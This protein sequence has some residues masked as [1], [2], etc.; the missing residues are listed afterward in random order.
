MRKSEKRQLFKNVGSSWFSLATN[1]V[2]GVL[3][4][5]FILHHLG[6]AAFGIWVLIFSITGYY[7]LFDLGIRSSIVRFVSKFSAVEDTDNLARVINTSFGIYSIIGILAMLVTLAGTIY[8]DSIF[9]IPPQ[10]HSTAQWLLLI[11]GTSVAI[12]FPLGV[13]GGIL[14]GLQRFDVL[15][16]TGL[17]ATLLRA[18]LIVIALK[19]GHGLLMIAIITTGLPLIGTLVRAWMAM[20]LVHVPIGLRYI[21]KAT[22]RSMANYSGLSFMIIISARLRFQTD[23]IVLGTMLSTAAITQF[24]IGA[25]IVD[26]ANDVVH[27]LAQIFVPMS[28]QSEAKGD[29]P[30][31]RKMLIGGN[32][33]CAFVILPICIVLILLGKALIEVWVG[34]KYVSVSYPVLVVLVIPFTLLLA[35]AVSARILIGMGR[36][37]TFG[38][39]TLIEGVANVV[40]SVLL[41]RP[42]G[43]FG[44]AVGTAIPLTCTMLVF[45]PR[46]I[47]RVLGVSVWTYLK[48][49]YTLPLLV[50]TPMLLTLLLMRRWFVPH[51]FLPLML[52]LAV[53]GAV[54]GVGLFWLYAKDHAFRIDE[55]VSAGNMTLTEDSVLPEHV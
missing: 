40:L 15:N 22:A 18:L 9:K 55:S 6:D 54:Y 12:G 51:R 43:V 52:H 14:E 4:S 19:H 20:N 35:Q 44:D 21:D 48:H 37:R 41:V 2:V 53:G 45:I 39:V 49:A 32:R 7:G 3:L 50:A 38:I 42:Y 23:E 13:F 27:G 47:C 5:P 24:S 29:M 25:R 46:H 33:A 11:V 28:S 34:P 36:H 26:Y 8:V 30:R 10:F 17:G 1:V 16:W 31:L